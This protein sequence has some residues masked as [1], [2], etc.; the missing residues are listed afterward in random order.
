MEL[1][2]ASTEEKWAVIKRL[3]DDL[4]TISSRSLRVV[5]GSSP[6]ADGPSFTE[7]EFD[8]AIERGMKPIGFFFMRTSA[9]CL[10]RKLNVLM[11]RDQ[12]LE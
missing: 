4:A 12:K 10:A 8:Y 6:T 1:F 7:M 2:P 9:L 11:Q 5:H 3:I